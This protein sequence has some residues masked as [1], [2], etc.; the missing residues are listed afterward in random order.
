MRIKI[1]TYMKAC[2][3]KHI[4]E[5]RVVTK[6]NKLVSMSLKPWWSSHQNFLESDTS[7]N[8]TIELETHPPSRHQYSRRVRAQPTSN[9]IGVILVPKLSWVHQG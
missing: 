9:V 6:P 4:K 7:K 5:D 3:P 8:V 1:M 2:K